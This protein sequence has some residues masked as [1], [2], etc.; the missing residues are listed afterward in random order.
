LNFS[1]LVDEYLKTIPNLKKL[2]TAAGKKYYQLALGEPTPQ[3]LGNFLEIEC[4][5]LVSCVENSLLDSREF[6][7][8]VVTPFELVQALDPNALWTAGNYELDVVKVDSKMEE[9]L[10]SIGRYDYEE[11]P[12]FSSITSAF[13]TRK[14][15]TAVEELETFTEDSLVK[16]RDGTVAK[17][18][19]TFASA[20]FLAKREYQGLEVKLGETETASIEVGRKGI[21]KSYSIEKS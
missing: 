21:A 1:N 6:M 16:R 11:E 7:V 18:T 15:A 19:D 3:K 4:F 17:I 12:V 8:P 2:I 5:V 9:V 13:T 10:Q 14:Y 20:E